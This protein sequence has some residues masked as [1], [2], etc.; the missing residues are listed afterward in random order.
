MHT[1]IVILTYNSVEYTKQCIASIRKYTAN[2]SYEIII[3]DNNS[4]DGTRQWIKLQKDIKY[5]FNQYNY[6]FPKAY[7]QGIRFSGGENILLMNSDVIAT[8]NWLSNLVYCLRSSN[9]IGVVGPVSNIC[10]NGQ[11][12]LVSYENLE[13]MQ[14]FAYNFNRKNSSLWVEKE[15]LA[16][17]C[18]LTK[19]EVVSKVGLLDERFFPG[20][21]EYD[22][23]SLR[24]RL[25]GY[26][27]L[28]C[29]DTFIHNY[30]RAAIS[31]NKSTLE[32]IKAANKQKFEAKWKNSYGNIFKD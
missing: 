25:S 14:K 20:V 1:S 6:G 19:R 23:Y 13:E 12:I 21:Y 9:D 30:S 4:N 24:I 32:D 26:R 8:S 17:F 31:N 27:L 28:L 18:F 10:S 16:G 29:K 22:D 15:R 2:G 7:N 11:D 3:V 5:I